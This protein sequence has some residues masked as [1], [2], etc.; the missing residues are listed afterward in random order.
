MGA[1]ALPLVAPVL[2]PEVDRSGLRL[3]RFAVMVEAADVAFGLARMEASSE[4]RNGRLRQTGSG[5]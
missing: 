1:A 3:L 4:V 5:A 2:G